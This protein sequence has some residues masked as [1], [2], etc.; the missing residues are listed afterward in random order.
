M[1]HVK[2]LTWRGWLA[3][4]GIVLGSGLLLLAGYSIHKWWWARGEIARLN[5]LADQDSLRIVLLTDSLTI[6]HRRVHVAREVAD[7]IGRESREALERANLRAQ[8]AY[9]LAI[10][11]RNQLAGP[12]MAYRVREDSH[13]PID[14]TDGELSIRGEIVLHD[15]HVPSTVLIDARLEAILARLGIEVV[16]AE[17]PATGGLVVQVTTTSPNVEVLDVTGVTDL[18]STPAGRKAPSGRK[19]AFGWGALVGF[20]VGIFVP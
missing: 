3:L 1:F 11:Y 14:L 19:E 6:Y 4:A 9:D 8:Q 18:R 15:H 17:D 7:K 12:A 2:H 16:V 13:I 10:G 20:V 5:D